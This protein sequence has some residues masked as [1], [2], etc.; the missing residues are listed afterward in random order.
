MGAC[1]SSSSVDDVRSSLDELA[2]MHGAL[3]EQFA[4]SAEKLDAQLVSVNEELAHLRGYMA[5]T[6]AEQVFAI[7]TVKKTAE[8][9]EVEAVRMRKEAAAAKYGRPKA[10]ASS[11]KG[12]AA[13]VLSKRALGALTGSYM[14]KV[15]NQTE[16]TVY[17]IVR[18]REKLQ[19]NM[20]SLGSKELGLGTQTETTTSSGKTQHDALTPAAE[21][22]LTT[23]D[24]HIYLTMYTVVDGQYSTHRSDVLIDAAETAEFNFLPR[25]LK[26]VLHKGT[27]C[28][29]QAV[30]RRPSFRMPS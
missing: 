16:E 17:Y 5:S 14:L 18:A 9:K 30:P 12:D 29:Y 13:D 2:K 1:A 27:D 23:S 7:D 4:L 6:S 28:P 20:T 19:K 10:A 25:H 24:Q 15:K 26:V 22:C 11:R 3:E 21:R 8:E